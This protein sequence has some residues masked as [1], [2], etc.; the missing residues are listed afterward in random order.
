MGEFGSSVAGQAVNAVFNLATGAVSGL[1]GQAFY[2]KNL[3]RQ[4]A[5]QKEL[6]D[7]QN[8]YNSPSAQMQRISEAGLNPNLVYGSSAPA[9]QSGNA[10]APSGA[11]P[12]TNGYNTS[13]VIASMLHLRQMKSIDSQIN[14]QEANAEK[15][16]AEA[17]FT[18]QQADRYNELVDVQINEAQSRINK[19][20]SDIEVNH[21]TIQYQ[22]AETLLAEA[23]EAY[24]R[25]EID[26][27]TYRKQQLI[28]Q[29]NLFRS[30]EALNRTQDYYLDVEG[31]MSVL[32]LEY[33]KLFYSADGR[34][35][36][37]SE[38]EYQS[39]LNA[40]KFQAS[41][42]AATLGIEGNKTTQWIDW[43]MSQI[44][45]ILGGAGTAA[46]GASIATRP[47]P[48]RRVKAL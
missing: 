7:Y 23:D 25:S 12:S 48:V 1:I 24:R 22:A 41:K 43:T 38:A 42:A 44:G 40:F 26:L 3:E 29:T 28:A 45:K 36:E 6:M 32:E 19:I 17:R 4:V 10:S 11:M 9:G 8:E 18:S 14:L 20:A 37:L 35:K 27:Q 15:A 30:Q 39:K 13:D 46:V 5:A 16:R 31:Q 33:Q 21:S 47:T 34:M 2:K